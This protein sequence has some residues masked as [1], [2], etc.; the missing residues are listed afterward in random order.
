MGFITDNMLGKLA[1]YL[2]MMGYD[3]IYPRNFGLSELKRLCENDG[4][5]F[6][7]RS[8]RMLEILDERFICFIRSQHFSEQLLQVITE[9]KLELNMDRCFSRCLICNTQLEDV[10]INDIESDVPGKV[11]STQS[12]FKVCKDCHRGYWNGGHTARM[13]DKFN[14]IIS[15]GMEED[16]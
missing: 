13:L 12:Q 6:L 2:R 4:Y 11:I 10:S 16:I 8:S 1:K 3:T 9:F 15:R 7:T 5:I 14:T